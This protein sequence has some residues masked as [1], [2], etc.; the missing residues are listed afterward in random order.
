MKI[1]QR[2]RGYLPVVIDIETGG[3]N[4]KTDAML[5]VCAIIIGINNDG[6]FYP[7]DPQHFHIE[8]FKGANLEPSALK[9]NGIDVYNPLRM[10][11]T[12]K[13]AL[14]EIFQTV[15]MEIKNEE[16]TRAI[17]V[18]HN[19]FFDLGFLRA[20][21][22]RSKLKSPFHQFST[23]DTVSLSALYYGETVLA[24]AMRVANIEWNDANAH[25][26]LYDTQKTAEL[27]CQIF[28][29]QQYN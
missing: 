21:T 13:Q 22:E 20:A 18:G 4:E 11:V 14:S 15:H 1:K 17:L 25:S 7:K 19:A 10:A 5:E 9:F 8:P 12:E 27:F 16:C 28:N 6:V 26:A 3:F 29:T 2:I 24:K 23:I